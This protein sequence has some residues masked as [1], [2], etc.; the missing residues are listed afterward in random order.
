MKKLN[1]PKIVI[2]CPMILDLLNQDLRVLE[3][4]LNTMNEKLSPG[5]PRPK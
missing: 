5:S 3:N 2:Y 1:I 4:K